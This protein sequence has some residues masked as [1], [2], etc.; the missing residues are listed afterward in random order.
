MA[1]SAMGSNGKL[2]TDL[3]NAREA[4]LD[5]ERLQRLRRS[6]EEHVR[7]GTYDGAV[8]IVARHGKLVMHEAVGKTD[9][10]ERRQART[11]DIFFLMSLTK[12]FTAVRVLMAVEEDKF[13]LNTPVCEVIPE[14]GMK[15]KER[16]TVYHILTHTS[17]LNTE[18]PYGLPAEQLTDIESVTAA[19]GNERIFFRPGSMVS[20]NPFTSMSVVATMVQRLDE[21]R[22]PFRRILSE[23]IFEPLG[24]AD[25]TLGLPD[26]IRDRLVPV[27]VR[28]RTPGLVEPLL[29]ESLNFL[30]TEQAELPAGGAVSTALDYFRFTEMLRQGGT[31]DGVRIL[32]PGIIRL[33]T[34]NHT[35]DLPN[36]IYDCTR[37]MYGWPTFPAYLGF[38]FFLRGEGIFPM[39]FGLLASSGT[40]GGLGAGSTM[41][42]IDPLRDLTFIFLS[43]GLLEEGNSQLRFQ[44]LSDLVVASVVD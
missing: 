10:K 7:K 8:W 23:D 2:S 41:F 12:Q 3:V 6:V 16:V 32:S 30:A 1:T 13:T 42:W 20:Y 38:T 33:A 39:P 44:R 31:L 21:K 28:D 34:S 17:G 24:M 9:A 15:G 29:L 5:A 22:R 43:S 14:F 37:E 35:G 26:R 11:D 18:I 4:G 25:T 40:Y 27:V 36:H 19:V